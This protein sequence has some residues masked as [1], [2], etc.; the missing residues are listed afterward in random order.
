MNR[1]LL[2]KAIVYLGEN[3]DNIIRDNEKY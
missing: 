3:N 2:L 1:L